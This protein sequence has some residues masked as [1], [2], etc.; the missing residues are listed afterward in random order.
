MTDTP[1][2]TAPGEAA[3]LLLDVASLLMQS[4]AHTERV[5][6]NTMRIA[7]SLGY[8]P[9]LFFS[10]SGI[11]IT[12]Q[13]KTDSATPDQTITQFRHIEHHGVQLSTVSAISRLSWRAKN[14]GLSFDELTQE[15]SR[16]THHNTY[17]VWFL[18]LM[19]PLGTAGLCGLAG[20][21]HMVMLMTA[22]A[23]FCGF[24]FRHLLLKLH[25]NP[26][27]TIASTALFTESI[28]GTATLMN[29]GHQ[30]ELAMATSILF[31]VPGIPLINSLIDMLHGHYIV[32]LA[33]GV[34]GTLV[35]FSIALGMWISM[36][37]LGVG[38][39]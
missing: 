38:L 12:L 36:S 7:T 34:H 22:L 9:E 28:A 2:F 4:G 1:S 26:F 24:I 35:A 15:I 19:A 21:D 17:P 11:T 33:R 29:V 27:L 23:T 30:P 14:I 18:I 13:H 25:Y 8:E 16:L 3:G 31:L 6:R 10:H 37:L 20:G 39:P 32:G 5:R